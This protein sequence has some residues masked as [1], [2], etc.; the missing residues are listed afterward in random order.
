MSLS[1]F[2][3]RCMG[4]DISV[5]LPSSHRRDALRAQRLFVDWDRRL[6]RFRRDSELSR[7]NASAGSDVAVSPAT[8]DVIEAALRAARATGGRFD[9]L[10]GARMVELGYDRTFASLPPDRPGRPLA[11][12]RPGLWREVR[13]D[14]SRSTVRVPIG[15]ALDLGGIAKGMAA[16]AAV[17][18]LVAAGVPY[19]LVNAGGDLS[20]RGVPPGTDGW[21]VNIDNVDLA[22]GAALLASGALA[23]SSILGRRWSRGGIPLHHL[24]DPHSG[25]PVEGELVQATVTA[26][27]CRQAEVAAKVAL[28]GTATEATAFVL[29]HGLTAALVTREGQQLRVGRWD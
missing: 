5:V 4:T 29:Q 3:F 19:V 26:T 6:S 8:L 22:G 9:P 12:W 21:A 25:M 23:T 11:A 10:L 7:A 17:A 1:T 28:L 14:R 16:D 24:L 15:G 27:S 20:T 2:R 13:I 18:E